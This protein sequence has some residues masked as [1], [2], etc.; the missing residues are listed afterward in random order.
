MKKG[1]AEQAEHYSERKDWSQWGPRRHNPTET[2]QC[3]R[4]HP[5]QEVMGTQT[6]KMILSFLYSEN[7][8][9]KAY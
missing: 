5:V 4:G 7:R 8:H 2:G 6:R 3:V 1:T 9:T